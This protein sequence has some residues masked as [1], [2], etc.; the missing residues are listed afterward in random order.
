MEQLERRRPSVPHWYLGTI[1]TDPPRQHTGI[2]S[3]V[4]SAMLPAIDA[5]GLPAY[6]ES[7]KRENLSFYQAHGF[8]ITGELPSDEDGRPRLWLMWRTPTGAG[9]VEP[10]APLS[11]PPG[12]GRFPPVA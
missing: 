1:G 11:S 8:V 7:S 12:A 4:L 9:E 6:L 5:D 3:A 10:S 2:G